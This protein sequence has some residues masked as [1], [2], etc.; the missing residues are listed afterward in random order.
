MDGI[1]FL[2]LR[3]TFF[4]HPTQRFIPFPITNK[5]LNI[6]HVVW[7]CKIG[8]NNMNEHTNML[9][10]YQYKHT[11]LS[12]SNFG[13]LICVSNFSLI[14]RICCCR[15]FLQNLYTS[16]HKKNPVH[17]YLEIEESHLDFKVLADHDQQCTLK[18][19]K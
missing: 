18:S 2:K 13:S 15:A 12:S 11:F 6:V 4:T 3:C 14:F 19:G 9:I 1:S 10:Y 8:N 16:C 7:N 5:N 17:Q